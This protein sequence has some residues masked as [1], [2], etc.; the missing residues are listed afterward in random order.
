MMG[1]LPLIILIYCLIYDVIQLRIYY[2]VNHNNK[3]GG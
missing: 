1:G 3:I 2:I